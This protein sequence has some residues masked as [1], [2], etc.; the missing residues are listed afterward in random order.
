VF[1]GT[2]FTGSLG[3]GAYHAYDTMGDY[4]D[5]DWWIFG[6]LTTLFVVSLYGL[7]RSLADNS[8]TYAPLKVDPTMEGNAQ[9]IA[10]EV[11]TIYKLVQPGSEGANLSCL[12]KLKAI[13]A[14]YRPPAQN[15][16]SPAPYTAPGTDPVE[17]HFSSSQSH[18]PTHAGSMSAPLIGRQDQ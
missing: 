8:K 9:E 18:S 11:T 4:S 13:R 3:T 16:P 12:N 2:F 15:E 6:S 17:V 10:A 1:F 14:N 7:C 5:D